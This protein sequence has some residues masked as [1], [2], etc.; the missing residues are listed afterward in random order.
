MKAKN[1][2]MAFVAIAATA[3]VSCTQEEE[4]FGGTDVQDLDGAVMFGTYLSNAPETRASVMDLPALKEKGF[5]VFGYYT[6]E[7]DYKTKDPDHVP[8]FMYNQEVTW[9]ANGD[10]GG[11]WQYAP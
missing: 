6:K 1:Y 7:K 3:T 8:N 4:L 2:L 10:K 11:M 5:G 9:K